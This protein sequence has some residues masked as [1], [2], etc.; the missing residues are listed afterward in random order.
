M[1]PCGGR[2]NSNPGDNDL[3]QASE[4]L[5]TGSEFEPQDRIKSQS[6]TK[7][8]AVYPLKT[9]AAQ[10]CFKLSTGKCRCLEKRCP[11]WLKNTRYCGLLLT[12]TTDSGT[13][14]SAAVKKL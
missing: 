13:F 12:C 9:R 3:S 1:S 5:M 10:G 11:E 14:S 2:C 6:C 8:G 7:I 4:I